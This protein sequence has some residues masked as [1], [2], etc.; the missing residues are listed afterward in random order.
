MFYLASLVVLLPVFQ[1]RSVVGDGITPI[2]P[3]PGDQFNAGSPCTIQWQVGENWSNFT[4]CKLLQSTAKIKLKLIL[5]Q[6]PFSSPYVRF[7]HP[8]AARSTSRKRVGWFKC[9]FFSFQLDMSRGKPLLGDIFLPGMILQSFNRQSWS[10]LILIC[11]NQFTN[12]ND[13]TNSKWTTRFTVS[14]LFHGKAGQMS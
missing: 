2:A 8:D 13:T 1:V 3:G 12:S 11:I 4:I 9:G 7:Q 14:T 6:K 10:S 5:R